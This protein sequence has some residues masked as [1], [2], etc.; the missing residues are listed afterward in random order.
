MDTLARNM[1]FDGVKAVDGCIDFSES[2]RM[3]NWFFLQENSKN[4]TVENHC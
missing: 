2:R 3:R 4:D 1:C